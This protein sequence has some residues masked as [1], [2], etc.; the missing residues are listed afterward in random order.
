MVQLINGMLDDGLDPQQAV[1]R[2][3]FVAEVEASGIPL[4]GV[5]IEEDGVD[6]ALLGGLRE[7]GHDV[8]A[9]EPRTSAVGWAQV[10]RREPDGSYIGGADRRADSLAAGL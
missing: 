2:P 3:R 10:I 4:W 7:R 5:A 1:D 8:R 6:D 9:I